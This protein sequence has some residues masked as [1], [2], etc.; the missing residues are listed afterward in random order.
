MPNRE[1]DLTDWF[2]DI[3]KVR[4]RFGWAP[5]IELEEGLERTAAWY[6]SLPEKTA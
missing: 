6:R 2:S 4:Q 3:S 1:W 5:K